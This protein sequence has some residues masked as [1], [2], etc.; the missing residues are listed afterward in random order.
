MPSGAVADHRGTPIRKMNS[1][2]VVIQ[3]RL[4]SGAR[5]RAFARS[6]KSKT[7]RIKLLA[8]AIG[9][10]EPNL[11]CSIMHGGRAIAGAKPF[12]SIR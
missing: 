10:Q 3:F 8:N 4:C 12:R 6:R 5:F 7:S 2:R 9:E 1:A 11:P